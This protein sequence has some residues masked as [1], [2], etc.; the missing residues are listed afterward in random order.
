VRTGFH[1]YAKFVK[2]P[3]SKKGPLTTFEIGT[4]DKTTKKWTNYK[5]VVW[6]NIPIVEGEKIEIKNI[7]G[8]DLNEFTG[9]D[10]VTRQECQII[11]TVAKS[12]ELPH[13]I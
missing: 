1:Y 13:D 2:H 8:V 9:S 11:A 5:I 10:G 4:Q 6:G 3:E 12:E 7:L